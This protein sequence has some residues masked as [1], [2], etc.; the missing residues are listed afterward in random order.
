MRSKIPLAGLLRVPP[1]PATMI[2]VLEFGYINNI[3]RLKASAIKIDLS[4]LI[5]IPQGLL[6]DEVE[7]P[8]LPLI[9][10]RIILPISNEAAKKRKSVHFF[11]SSVS[12][13]LSYVHI[14]RIE[15][16]YD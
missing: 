11:P 2:A 10:P 6:S 4:A 5:F 8:G 16:K 12:K 13:Y 14:E 9:F 7:L 3:L 15:D 1:A